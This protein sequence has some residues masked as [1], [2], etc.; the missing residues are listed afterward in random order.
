MGPTG[1]KAYGRLA[2]LLE[3]SHGERIALLGLPENAAWPDGATLTDEQ[4]YRIS[5][6]IGIWKDTAGLFGIEAAIRRL[7]S[8]R[9]AEPVAG[10]SLIAYLIDEGMSA[11]HELRME[12]AYWAHN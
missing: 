2:N 7:N 12:A 10:R 6:L 5:Y 4:F 9:Q 11:F 1:L 3:L 8:P